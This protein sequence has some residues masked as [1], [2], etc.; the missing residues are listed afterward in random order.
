MGGAQK[1]REAVQIS[2]SSSGS[3]VPRNFG[4]NLKYNELMIKD[5]DEMHAL[6]QS[7]MTKS[8]AT[9][10]GDGESVEYLG[11]ALKLIFSRPDTDNM[12]TKLLAEVRRDLVG[13]SVY[14]ET[15]EGLAVDAL[16]TAKN[17]NATVISGATA[18]V[19]LQNILGEIRP[20][21][22]NGNVVL[23][24]IAER[25]RDAR[26]EI[27]DEVKRERRLRGMFRSDNP[28]DE[29]RALLKSI[30]DKKK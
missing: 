30:G 10:N 27:S 13:Y 16:I 8:H 4:P 9:T 2:P 11:R 12:V 23:R 22:K 19:E 14:D 6:V 15:L 24:R 21:V 25:I 20:E 17:P 5:Y 28:S 7:L 26:L 1:E 29:A 18:I 3:L